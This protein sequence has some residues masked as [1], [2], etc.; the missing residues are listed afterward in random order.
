[1]NQLI[2]IKTVR[3]G[4]GPLRNLNFGREVCELVEV[5]EVL[6]ALQK[7][8]LLIIKELIGV[9]VLTVE[10]LDV[11]LEGLNLII[12]IYKLLCLLLEQKRPI[13][14]IESHQILLPLVDLLKVSC[15][16][17]LPLQR[18]CSLLS[19]LCGIIEEHR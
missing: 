9:K 7:N 8:L 10:H 6:S 4:D 16:I 1:M 11:L 14:N 18:V 5:V 13:G 2:L 19:E 3:A 15:L 17:A 12:K